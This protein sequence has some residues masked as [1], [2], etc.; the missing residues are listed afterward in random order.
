MYFRQTYTV[1]IV[2]DTQLPEELSLADVIE[3]GR[4][5]CL[6][7]ALQSTEEVYE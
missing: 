5:Q 6:E 1:E 7:F 4:D 2:S 3:Q